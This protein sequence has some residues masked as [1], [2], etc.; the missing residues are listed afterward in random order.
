MLWMARREFWTRREEVDEL[1]HELDRLRRFT[2]AVRHGFWL[3]L[4]LLGLLMI[5]ATPLY[6]SP[7][8]QALLG[9]PGRVVFKARLGASHSGYVPPCH[10]VHG[11]VY[12]PCTATNATAGATYFPSGVST[13]SP[14]AIAVYWL[15]ALPLAYVI[16][17]VWAHRRAIR[18]G[19]ATSML[20]YALTGIVLVALMVVSGLLT[21]A[22]PTAARLSSIGNRG[23]LAL[24][25]IALG[26][27]V[28]A[29]RERSRA[30]WAISLVFLGYVIL[31]NLYDLD[32]FIARFGISVGPEVGV[33]IGG[34]FTLLAGAVFAAKPKPQ[35]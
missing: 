33:F 7:S 3:P 16:L 4:V 27:L 17:A 20:V 2:R 30:M 10:V 29:Y 6:F 5:G 9:A 21:G 12:T 23:L 19:V 35:L 22:W 31:I 8:S 25:V 1:L 14:R 28:L 13:A 34:V 26:L 11:V 15:I 24:L 18:R 32:N